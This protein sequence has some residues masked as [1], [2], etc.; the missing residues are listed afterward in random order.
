MNMKDFQAYVD[1]LFVSRREGIDGKLHAAIGMSGES[2]ECLDLIKKSWVY[3]KPL[4]TA[5]LQ[6]EAGDT[7]HYIVMLCIANGWTLEDLA[8]NNKAKLDKRYPNGYT[9]AAA[10]ARADMQAP[11]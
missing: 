11:A 3:G 10:I 1:G 8:N 4:D 2:A 9:N 5:K 7:L 6:E